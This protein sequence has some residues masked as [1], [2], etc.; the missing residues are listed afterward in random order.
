[1]SEVRGFSYV[2]TASE[3]KEKLEMLGSRENV[4]AYINE[5]YSLC[6][7]VTDIKVVG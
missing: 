6:R 4:I 5:T 1:M 3:Y 2:M 7:L